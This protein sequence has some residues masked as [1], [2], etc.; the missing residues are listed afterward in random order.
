M[1]AACCLHVAVVDVRLSL[2]AVKAAKSILAHAVENLAVGTHFALLTVSHT[3]IGV[4]DLQSK[5]LPEVVYTS[6]RSRVANSIRGDG[7]EYCTVP[8][9]PLHEMLNGFEHLSISL[10]DRNKMLVRDAISSI[11]PTADDQVRHAMHQPISALN[12]VIYSINE[13]FLGPGC[14]S[15]GGMEG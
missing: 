12:G 2:D 14:G 9:V 4:F 11:Q 6:F 10:N 3:R 15:V 13:S 5:N 7:S 1:S 8:T